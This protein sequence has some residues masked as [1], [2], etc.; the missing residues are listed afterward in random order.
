MPRSLSPQNT[1]LERENLVNER[2]SNFPI[3][4]RPCDAIPHSRMPSC[5][6]HHIARPRLMLVIAF[7]RP[8]FRSLVF[9]IASMNIIQVANNPVREPIDR[10]SC[11]KTNKKR[12]QP[13]R[14]PLVEE[15]HRQCEPYGRRHYECVRNYPAS[16][17]LWSGGVLI[18]PLTY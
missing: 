4:K 9:M 12:Q 2:P 3:V 1:Y 16:K 5:E 8:H 7:C 6:K 17:I 18:K 10:W 14:N 13:Q 11:N 15:Y